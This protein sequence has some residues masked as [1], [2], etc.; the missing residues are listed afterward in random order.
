V[1]QWANGANVTAELD[2]MMTVRRAALG[3]FGENV[4]RKG[5]PVALVEETLVPLYL[6]HRY[7]VEAVASAVGGLYYHYA[8]RGDGR[9]PWSF[10]PAAEQRAA[11]DALART[12]APS[13]LAVPGHILQ[14][15]APRPDGFDRHRELFPRNTGLPFD[16][17]MPAT[18]AADMTVSFVLRPDRAARLVNQKALDASLPG[19]DEVLDRVIAAGFDSKRA[20]GY[21][22][23]IARAV[24][25][26]VVDRLMALAGTAPAPQVR[27]IASQRLRALR[28]RAH[29]RA[30]AADGADAAFLALVAEDIGRFLDRPAEAAK[31]VSP[32]APPPGAP[33]GDPDQWWF[34]ASPAARTPWWQWLWEGYRGR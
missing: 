12:L 13:E 4:V 15:L 3:R 28:E 14:L 27:A 5:D 2:R 22:A 23:E 21:E 1:D 29:T 25:R 33:I 9:P 31:P 19:L 24:G 30:S 20:N 32:P 16:V 6:H 34:D 26:V 8:L 17:L 10:V 7:Q 11:L 18:V